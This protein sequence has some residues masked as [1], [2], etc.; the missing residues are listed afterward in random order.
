[1]LKECFELLKPG[2][3]ML[4]TFNDCDLPHN[5]DLVERNWKYYTPGRL[6]RHYIENTGFTVLK[7]FS[8]SYGMAWFE[9]EKPGKLESIK[10]GQVLASIHQKNL[11]KLAP[12][13]S[14]NNEGYMRGEQV[15]YKEHNYEAR[16]NLGVHRTW[17]N[18]QW[19]LVE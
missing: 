16:R 13:W 19:K 4:F 11:I 12:P 3:K 2:G 7:H 18:S 15:S 1:M 8:E 5:I 17:D 14:P 6:V 10:G 9:I